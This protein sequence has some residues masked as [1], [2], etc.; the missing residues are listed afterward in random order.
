[1]P[2][3]G[4]TK[5]NPRSPTPLSSGH[6]DANNIA[7]CGVETAVFGVISPPAQRYFCYSS[8]KGHVNVISCVFYWNHALD[9][10]RIIK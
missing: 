4:N 2:I 6:F 3:N 7:F 8:R 10:P 5:K 9:L 1:M